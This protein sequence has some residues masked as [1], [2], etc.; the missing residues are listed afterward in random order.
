MWQ[1]SSKRGFAM[2]KCGTELTFIPRKPIMLNGQCL[3]EFIDKKQ[4]ERVA[5][6]FNKLLFK[7]DEVFRY[8]G[9]L[10]AAKCD[11]FRVKSSFNQTHDSYCIEVINHMSW[12]IQ[13]DWRVKFDNDSKKV[14]T[15]QKKYIDTIDIVFKIAKQL[16]LVSRLE[17]KENGKIFEAPNGGGHL[18]YSMDFF[19]SGKNYFRQMEMVEKCLAI[20]YYN[21]PFIKWLFCQWSDDTNSYICH[22]MS[23]PA[24]EPLSAD[25]AWDVSL[26]S[27]AICQ[28]FSKYGKTFYGAYEF[29]FFNAQKDA[30]DLV[31]D[32]R[33]LYAWINHYIQLVDK[34]FNDKCLD[35]LTLIEQVQTPTLTHQKFKSLANLNYARHQMEYFFARIGLSFSDYEAKFQENYIR[36]M[37]WGKML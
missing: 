9:L 8:Y 7:H 30:N 34:A 33:F 14:S 24:S 11:P 21:F 37:K 4:G 22:N 25:I 2:S 26:N 27:H 18:T 12:Q 16:D 35:S 17:Y 1:Y 36:R 6:A 3:H 31:L 10:F 13:T 32:I 28:R 20:D 5:K 29:R 19:P 23:D 15:Y